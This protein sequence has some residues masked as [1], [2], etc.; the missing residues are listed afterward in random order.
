MSRL[1]AAGWVLLVALA[2]PR[3]VMAQNIIEGRVT[4]EDGRSTENMR[5]FLIDDGSQQRAMTYVDASGRFR[6]SAAKGTYLVQVEAAGSDYEPQSV[7]V[8]IFNPFARRS[9][10]THVDIVLK[11][12]DQ[13][14]R[15]RAAP[16]PG[17]ANIVFSQ[18]VPQPAREAYEKAS[19]SL[20]KN[21]LS[22]AVNLLKRALEIFPDYFDALETLGSEYVKQRSYDEA[23]PSLR[24][25]LQVNDKGWRSHYALGVA[26]AETKQ[27]EEG[28]VELRRAVELNPES[29][30]TNMRLGMELAKN[31]QTYAEAIR[32]L[33]K[34]KSLAGKSIPDAYF[35]LASLYSKQEQY[36]E[37]ADALETY[38]AAMPNADATQ[39]AQYQRA[40][41]RLRQ[42]ATAKGKP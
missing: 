29:P 25:A 2:A 20:A 13:L 22:N 4:T 15:E 3:V 30:N 18:N 35:Y 23:I 33:E 28:I 39:R 42:K 40:I 19:Q 27:R 8:E 16:P 6:F 36:A 26:L 7:R 41:E 34:V 31:Q 32:A 38:L 10:P 14:K 37:A 5:V 21:D 11:L 17:S 9:T 12:R 24:R 1:Y